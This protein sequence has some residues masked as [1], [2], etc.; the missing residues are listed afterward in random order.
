MINDESQKALFDPGFSALAITFPQDIYSHLEDIAACKQNH[1]KKFY[2]T[3]LESQ[4]VSVTKLCTSFYLG[5]ILWGSYLFYRNKQVPLEIQGNLTAEL[6]IEE[7]ED[8]DYTSE[9][10]FILEFLNKFEQSS[11]YYL[12]RKSKLNPELIAYLNAYKE[13]VELNDNFK[14]L[15]YTDKIKLPDVVSHLETYDNEQ[16]DEL[17]EKIEAI[18]RSKNLEAILDLGFY[19]NHLK[20]S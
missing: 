10:T 16:L 1:Q 14:T 13:F 17:K 4:V 5:C 7:L 20:T 2:F 19:K 11:Q 3:K 12:K 6:P 8:V 18:I 9:V 15:K